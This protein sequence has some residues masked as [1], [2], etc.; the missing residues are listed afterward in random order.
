M[1]LESQTDCLNFPAAH[2]IPDFQPDINVTKFPSPFFRISVFTSRRVSITLP[3]FRFFFPV[4]FS[5]L[6]TVFKSHGPRQNV[7]VLTNWL[8]NLKLI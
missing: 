2:L 4:G 5:P 1:L 8:K 7:K 6:D 3:L